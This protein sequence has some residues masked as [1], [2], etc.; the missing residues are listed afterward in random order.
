M[1]SGKKERLEAETEQDGLD[2]EC[3]EDGDKPE[4]ESRPLKKSKSEGDTDCTDKTSNGDSPSFNCDILSL[5]SFCYTCSVMVLNK[6]AFF[7]EIAKLSLQ[8]GY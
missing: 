1:Q 8:I 5:P 6:R 3:V 2:E 4:E 7:Q